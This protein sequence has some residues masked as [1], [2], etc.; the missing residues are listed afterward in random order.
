M[1][2]ACVVSKVLW[3]LLCARV[4][5]CLR[6]VLM[7]AL[8]VDAYVVC[9]LYAKKCLLSASASLFGVLGLK[10]SPTR[11]KLGT[12]NMMNVDSW[13]DLGGQHT[14]TRSNRLNARSP[15]GGRG[16]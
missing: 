1:K 3:V 2:R 7:L 14:H 9:G 11:H 5:G 12:M 10:A 4:C 16:A 15:G 8:C 13:T 6:C